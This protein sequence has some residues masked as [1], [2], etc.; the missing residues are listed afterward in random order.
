MA[1]AALPGCLTS[2]ACRR[3]HDHVRSLVLIL[4]I[5]LLPIRMWAAEGMSVRMAAQ[6]PATVSMAMASLDAMDDMPPDCPMRA[7]TDSTPQDGSKGSAATCLSCQLCAA[8]DVSPVF[9]S[10]PGVSTAAPPLVESSRFHSA[11]AVRE[12]KPP[13][14]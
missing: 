13:I 3:Y 11:D 12:H 9:E 6:G 8:L 4:M 1:G 7:A 10:G 2:S 5:A 14:S